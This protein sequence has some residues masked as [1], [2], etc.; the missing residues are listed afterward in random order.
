MTY[1]STSKAFLAQDVR[2]KKHQS[3]YKEYTII[4]RHQPAPPKNP[5]RLHKLAYA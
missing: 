2:R 4:T 5:K 3:Q 1:I